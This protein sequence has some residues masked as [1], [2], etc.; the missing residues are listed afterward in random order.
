MN[1]FTNFA[2]T[3]AIEKTGDIG[4]CVGTFQMNEPITP[5][6]QKQI[7]KGHACLDKIE[8]T[9]PPKGSSTSSSPEEKK[10]K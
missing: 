10:K 3:V 8:A 2:P 6:V 7:D 9:L 4:A 5:E 1:A